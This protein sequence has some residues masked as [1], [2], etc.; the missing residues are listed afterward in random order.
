MR[1]AREPSLSVLQIYSEG[2]I[3]SFSCAFAGWIRWYYWCIAVYFRILAFKA[4]HRTLYHAEHFSVSQF[5]PRGCHKD[6]H[7]FFPFYYGIHSLMFG[8]YPPT[9]IGYP[10]TAIGYPPTAISYPPTAIGYTPTAIGYPPTAIGYPP[11]TIG[12]TPTAIGYTPTAIGYPPTAISYPPAAIGYT[13]TVIGYPPTAIGYSPAAIVGRIGHSEFFF[14]IMAPPVSAMDVGHID[15]TQ[16]VL[17][18]ISNL[19]GAVLCLPRLCLPQGL[20]PPARPPAKPD[21]KAANPRAK[22]STKSAAKPAARVAAKS[23]ARE[24]IP[25]APVEHLQ[26]FRVEYSRQKMWHRAC[27]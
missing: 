9:A 2:R 6:A 1:G 15:R 10:P 19:L 11:T 23:A 22:P 24:P 26:L 8:G 3:L 14:S 7:P 13:P 4:L 12:Y 5:Q 16:F 20:E 21:P 18:S 25:V 17:L 27:F